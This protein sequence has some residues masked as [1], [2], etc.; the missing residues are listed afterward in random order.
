MAITLNGT[1][2]TMN[3]ASTL[4]STTTLHAIGSYGILY[5]LTSGTRVG[6]GTTLAGT[7][8]AYDSYSTVN[9]VASSQTSMYDFTSP[10]VS[11]KINWLVTRYI[12]AASPGIGT[13]GTSSSGTW[14]AMNASAHYNANEGYRYCGS[15][16][17][18]TA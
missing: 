4:V 11:V 14:R 16:W 12:D 18:R 5:N 8:L 15:L 6:A 1:T 7:S 3:D 17:A 2:I 13:G 10:T 9:G